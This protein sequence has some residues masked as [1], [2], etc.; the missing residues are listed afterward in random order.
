[1][2][3]HQRQI[4]HALFAH[5]I[6]ANIAM[7]DVESMLAHLGAE[8]DNRQKSRIGVKLRGHTAVFHT[9]PHHLAKDEVVQLRKF[10]A[11]CGI[12]PARDFPL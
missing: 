6:S 12:E 2:N 5:P 7:G 8:I 10:I 9:P 3:H 11:A 4:L 1:M